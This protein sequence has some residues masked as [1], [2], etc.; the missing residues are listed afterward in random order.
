MKG[1]QR[2]YIYFLQLALYSVAI[3]IL[4]SVSCAFRYEFKTNHEEWIISAKP[5]L[6]PDV[7]SRVTAAINT[8]QENAK[9]LYKVKMEM[10]AALKSLLKVHFYFYPS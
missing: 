2:I 4:L 7:S 3:L 10:R 8:I 9:S 1:V 5:R 6:G